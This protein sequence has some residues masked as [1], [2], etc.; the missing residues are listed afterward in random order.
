MITSLLLMSAALQNPVVGGP[1]PGPAEFWRQSVTFRCG[2]DLLEI[3]GYGPSRPL[4]QAVRIRLNG[5]TPVGDRLADLSR[6]LGR[7]R[8]VYRITALCSREGRPGI[9][10]LYYR[11]ENVG[12][13][14]VEYHSAGAEFRNGRLTSYTG[15]QSTDAEGFWFR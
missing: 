13:G 11:G 6:D 2:R 12:E 5:R 3:A 8:A 15:L 7:A 1:E 9:S 4:G 10:V 14:V